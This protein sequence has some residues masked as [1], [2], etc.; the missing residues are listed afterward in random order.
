VSF[1]RFLLA[2]A[3]ASLSPRFRLRR[4]SLD[5]KLTPATS[6]QNVFRAGADQ[7]GQPTGQKSTASV[8]AV[9]ARERATLPRYLRPYPTAPD[10]SRGGRE[11]PHL[12]VGQHLRASPSSS[13]LPGHLRVRARVVSL[14]VRSARGGHLPLDVAAPAT[15]TP[16]DLGHEPD[17]PGGVAPHRLTA[18]GEARAANP[19]GERVLRRP[20]R[21]PACTSEVP[22]TVS[23][24]RLYGDP[25]SR[26]RPPR[27]A[28]VVMA[29]QPGSRGGRARRRRRV[30]QRVAVG[31]P[32]VAVRATACGSGVARISRPA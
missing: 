32:L 17:P 25:P 11:A 5:L 6:T 20:P 16:E 26:R 2:T 7:L 4:F 27:A 24:D 3:D 18:A 31:G 15:P 28:S 10:P 9:P 8:R 23:G 12:Q 30:V 21:R 14:P 22:G 19:T 13:G 29:P 1:V